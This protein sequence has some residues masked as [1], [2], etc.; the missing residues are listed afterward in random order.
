MGQHILLNFVFRE[1][2]AAVPAEFISA[3]VFYVDAFP[4]VFQLLFSAVAGV[5]VA[6]PGTFDQ[7]TEQVRLVI[8]CGKDLLTVIW[9][10]L[11]NC[12]EVM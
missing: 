12:S 2:S 6:A 4:A 10:I 8:S 1:V 9:R 11:S 5:V 3:A 7:G